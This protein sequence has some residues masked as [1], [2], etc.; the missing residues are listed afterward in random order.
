MLTVPLIRRTQGP[1]VYTVGNVVLPPN[2]QSSFAVQTKAQIPAGVYEIGQH[3]RISNQQ[4]LLSHSIVQ[5]KDKRMVCCVWNPTDKI[6]R[7][8]KHTPIGTL[9]SVE[10]IEPNETDPPPLPSPKP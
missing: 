3:A 2:S 7:F 4:V 1:A 10:A 6:M 9:A 8:R 5:P